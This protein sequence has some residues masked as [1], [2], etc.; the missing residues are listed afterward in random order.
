VEASLRNNGFSGL[1]SRR[2][3]GKQRIILELKEGIESEIAAIPGALFDNF[4]GKLEWNALN[5][6]DFISEIIFHT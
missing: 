1:K 5:F 3:H 4:S 6:K 2:Y